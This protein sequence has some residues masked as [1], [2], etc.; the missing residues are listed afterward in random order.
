MKTCYVLLFLAQKI[1]CGY[2]STYNLCL[3]AKVKKIM[4]TPVNPSFTIYK[5]GVR[6][7]INYM[8]VLSLIM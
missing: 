8:G 5:S 4:Y 1:D 7:G 2:T 6:V 3:I